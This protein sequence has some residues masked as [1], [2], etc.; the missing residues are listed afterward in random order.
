LVTRAVGLMHMKKKGVEKL[1]AE[2]YFSG[3]IRQPRHMLYPNAVVR[4]STVFLAHFSLSKT[5]GVDDE[6]A[7]ET[8]FDLPVKRSLELGYLD[9]QTIV[10]SSGFSR[11][12][13]IHD[14]SKMGQIHTALSET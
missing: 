10:Y 14:I 8:G 5:C 4:Y 6:G 3:R 1:L 9:R 11:I 7:L 12:M 2:S 13:R